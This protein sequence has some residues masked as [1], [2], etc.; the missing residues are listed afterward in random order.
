MQLVQL[1]TI[2]KNIKNPIEVSATSTKLLWHNLFT[3]TTW[4]AWS[5]CVSQGYMFL[6]S[7]GKCLLRKK[8]TELF[9]SIEFSKIYN[10]R[11]IHPWP[12]APGGLRISNENTSNK[13]VVCRAPMG[14]GGSGFACL[15]FIWSIILTNVPYIYTVVFGKLC[16]II[17]FM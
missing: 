8:L 1:N 10:E 16:G 5:P 17:I 14:K 2:K 9:L 11:N 15:Q 6:D 13:S 3:N 7:N 12:C 4:S